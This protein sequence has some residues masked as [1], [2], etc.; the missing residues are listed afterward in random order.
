M[1]PIPRRKLYQEVMDRLIERIGAGE[2]APGDQL[3]SE[4]ELM[5]RFQVG[6]P[7]IREA[8]QNLDRMGIIVISHGERAR[9]SRPTAT[10]VIDQ[11]AHAARHILMTSPQ[12][13]DHL[14]E[15]RLAF[16]TAIVRRATQCATP[17]DVDRLKARLEAHR[18][19]V[20]DPEQFLEKD[21]LFHR[22]IAAITGNPIYSALSQ[23]MF[24]WL[25]E[26]HVSMV[27]LPGSE[28]LTLKE[29]AQILDRIAAGDADG[30][31]GAMADHLTRAN[32][33]YRQFEKPV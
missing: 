33:L 31:A 22:E 21:M 5:Q 7:A 2:F 15:A 19:A 8:M 11:I 30:A 23:A 24:Q 14:K 25:A 1:E 16:E 27:R 4:R 18:T 17:E 20:K 13:M 29:H 12:T 6:R 10:S 9:V 3:P 26:F 28:G 32:T